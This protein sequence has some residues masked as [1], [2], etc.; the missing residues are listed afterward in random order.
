MLRPQP[1]HAGR[2]NADVL[3][4]AWHAGTGELER[5]LAEDVRFI[6]WSGGAQPC[7]GRAEVV[8]LV[9]ALARSAGGELP[10]FTFDD[11][12]DDV[13]LACDARG[14]EEPDAPY[15]A[16]AL[17][18]R[19]ATVALM[20]DYGSRANALQLAPEFDADAALAAEAEQALHSDRPL[21]AAAVDSIRAGDVETLRQLLE[22]DPELSTVRL[23]T[24]GPGAMTRTLLHVVTDWPGHYPRGAEAV[25]LLVAAGADVNARFTGPHAE[26]PLHWAASSDDVEVLDALLDAG[27]DIE[28]DGAVIA[29]GT[30][31]SDATAFGQ[32]AAARR[33]IERGAK[34]RL[35]EA[36][37]LGLLER[38]RT[39]LET[40]PD[41]SE[42][43][44]AF[45]MA[46]HGGQRATAEI[47]LERGADLN[48]IGY[49]GLTPLDAA[50]RSGAA[51]VVA[52]L[53]VLG[54]RSTA[55]DAH[56]DPA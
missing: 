3:S 50:H 51:E 36:A 35:G 54:A 46:C 37:S 30:A 18:I 34:A 19:H 27:A 6:W 8:A 15:A 10:E 44:S 21:A 7:H 40:S 41:K 9:R 47:L 1:S 25:A 2:V 24:P 42:V 4:R 31:L 39:H 20:V 12:R 5:L 16:I 52:W 43:T 13:V 55:P 26:T 29:H 38:V 22:Q 14:V 11:V 17:H 49:D 56:P 53:R 28:A 32:W 33:L 48:W 45:W 23:G